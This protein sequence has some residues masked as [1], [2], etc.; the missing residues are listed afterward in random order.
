MLC[1]KHELERR[2]QLEVWQLQTPSKVCHLL[3]EIGRGRIDE[4][5]QHALLRCI[6]HPVSQRFSPGNSYLNRLLKALV[7]SAEGEQEALIDELVELHQSIL[8]QPTQ[9]TTLWCYKTY[10]YSAAISDT[11]RSSF[12]SPAGPGDTKGLISLHVSQD[13]LEGS[14]GCHEW[15]AGFVLSEYILSHAS[16]FKGKRCAELGCGPGL[17]GVCLQR[18][19]VGSIL[20]TDGDAETLLNCRHNLSINAMPTEDIASPSTTTDVEMAQFMWD[21][22]VSLDADI[23]LGADLLYDPGSHAALVKIIRSSLRNAGATGPR[24]MILATTMRNEKACFREHGTMDMHYQ[25]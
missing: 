23:L 2:L 25:V 20:L 22:G 12:G 6:S 13:L 9:A 5:A 14:T 10:S 24:Q 3:R 8:L 19:G 7:L 1:E 18:L 15:E 21:D 4:G 16:L 17:V 11:C